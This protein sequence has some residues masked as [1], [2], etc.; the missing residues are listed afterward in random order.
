VPRP[1]VLALIASA[2]LGGCARETPPTRVPYAYPAYA[3][4]YAP[5][6]GVVPDP[7]FAAL[8]PRTAPAWVA[9]APGPVSTPAPV[10]S[11]PDV[12]TFASSE[13]PGGDAC[14]TEL[15][16][17]GVAFQRLDDKRG[18]I[19]P[20]EVTGKINGIRYQ[21]GAS[22]SMVADCRLVLALH[23]VAPVL[24]SLGVTTIRFSG[25]YSYRMSRVG[26]LSLHAH[27]L[28]IDVHEVLFG[29]T[30]QS[31]AGDYARGLSDGCA[32]ASP[33]LN[34]LACRLRATQLFRELL[35]P[36]YDAD[37]ANHLHLAIAPIELPKPEP[38]KPAAK[39]K[40]ATARAAPPTPADDGEPYVIPDPPNQKAPKTRPKRK[41]RPTVPAR[42]H[43]PTKVQPP[44]AS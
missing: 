20:V 24:A 7:R 43:A 40:P 8:D 26:R 33:L 36:D 11:R 31:V 34:Q 44:A 41:P 12:P 42:H 15:T 38:S 32:S 17:V 19:T 1:V 6:P 39:P 16:R 3:Y 4:G 18:V 14:I 21:S 5:A 28:A 9:G 22:S 13:I 25:A 10:A 2:A 37:H 35:T 23:R 29:A 30:W 27:G